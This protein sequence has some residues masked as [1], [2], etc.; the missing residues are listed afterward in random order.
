VG[1]DIGAVAGG[2]WLRCT[3][4][5]M[6]ADSFGQQGKRRVVIN[7][8]EEQGLHQMLDRFS[9]IGLGSGAVGL[10]VDCVVVASSR[11]LLS[12]RSSAGHS[13]RGC[14]VSIVLLA[15]VGLVIMVCTVQG[16]EMVEGKG[17]KARLVVLVMVGW[18]IV[19]M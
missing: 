18:E 13:S 1:G 4:W 2:I 10:C 12:T 8:W 17:E 9:G 16:H 7:W 5:V 11:V 19:V 14:W 3:L 6:G 15:S